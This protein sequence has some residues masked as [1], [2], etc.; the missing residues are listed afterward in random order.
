MRR[1]AAASPSAR[2][3][4]A[5]AA[6]LPDLDPAPG[7]HPDRPLPG[8]HAGDHRDQRVRVP[9]PA[10]PVVL[11]VGRRQRRHR[12]RSSSTARSR[13]GS[14]TPARSATC[15]LG[16]APGELRTE[17]AGLRRDARVS[18]RGA[19]A[20][21]PGRGPAGAARLPDAPHLDVHARRAGCTSPSTCCSCGSSATTSRTRW[22]GSGSSSSICSEALAAALAQVAI[23][24][25]STTPLVG[26]SGAIAA[27]L[28]GYALLYPRARVLTLFFVFFIF[29]VEIP[30][31][32]LLG[33]WIFLQFLPAVGQLAIARRRRRGRGRLLRPHRRLPVRPG[34]D[35]AVRAHGAA[36]HVRT[37]RSIRSTRG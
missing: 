7:Q 14:P 10:G 23:D 11:A 1:A 3:A 28:G 35:Q 30:A 26:A 15:V 29:I 2:P 19:A 33:L 6:R 31:M 22:A 20:G 27:V 34:G 37:D 12:S 21:R 13:T 24:P 9:V 8:R 17:I 4:P 36:R 18:A 16:P 25:D 32:L 5:A